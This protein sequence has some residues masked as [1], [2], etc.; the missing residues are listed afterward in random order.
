MTDASSP[1]SV[2]LQSVFRQP[3]TSWSHD[4][5]ADLRQTRRIALFA[6]GAACLVACLEAVALA[7][8]IPLK[9]VVPYTIT[10]DRQTGAVEEAQGLRPGLLPANQAL[11]QSFIVQYVIGRETFDPSDLVENFHRVALWSSGQALQSYRAAMDRNDPSSAIHQYTSQTMV[12]V[13]VTG[14]SLISS[15]TAMVRFST[16]Q[17]DNGAS[18][19]APRSWTA[20]IAFHFVNAPMAVGDRYLNPLGFQVT[21]YR[22][23]ADLP[24]SVAS[25]GVVA[26]P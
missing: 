24:L 3:A 4:V 8:L 23:D 18:V 7:C 1:S 22:R 13:S 11:L 19:T 2:G 16:E 10:V 14:I 26:H 12:K 9:T 20:V 5:N 21:R 15:S 17:Q 6:A 25:D